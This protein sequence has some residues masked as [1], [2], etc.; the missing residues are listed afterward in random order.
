MSNKY[1]EEL[2][3]GLG[4]VRWGRAD[5]FKANYLFDEKQSFLHFSTGYQ[6][7]ASKR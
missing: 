7:T 4:S 2:G 5:N 3:D 6:E 1:K